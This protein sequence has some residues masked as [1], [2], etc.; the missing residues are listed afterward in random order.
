MGDCATNILSSF[1]G[2]TYFCIQGT[3]MAAPHAAGV[4]ALIVSQFGTLGSD[5]DVKMPPQ[6]VQ[7]YLQSTTVDIGLPG[8]DKCFG[9]GRINALRAVQ[10]DTSSVY[11][12]TAP[13][14]PEYAE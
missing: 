11:D 4:A 7:A 8:Y 2:N 14:C 1:P 10:Y 13:F 12:A 5:G 9:D 6:Q 3:S